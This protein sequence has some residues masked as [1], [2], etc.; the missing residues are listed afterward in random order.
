[1]RTAT[2]TAPSDL[3]TTGGEPELRT[4]HPARL[5]PTPAQIDAALPPLVIDATPD[6]V[7]RRDGERGHSVGH[8]YTGR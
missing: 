2:V 5:Q 1:M 7:V 6:M 4:N 3:P 8:D